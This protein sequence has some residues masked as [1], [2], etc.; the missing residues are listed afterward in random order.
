MNRI[1]GTI[2]NKAD[3]Y[4][5]YILWEERNLDFINNKSSVYAEVHI[6]CR[7]HSSYAS[8]LKQNLWING[9]HFE[10]VLSVSLSP[11]TDI[12][13][14]SGQVDN[15]YHEADG[16][17]SINISSNSILPSGNG[18]GPVGGSASEWVW[19]THFPRQANF[20]GY[21]INWTWIDSVDIAYSLDR[22]VQSLLVSINDGPWQG[23]DIISGNWNINAVGR[24]YNLSPNTYYR[25][26]LKATV[27]GLDT[28]SDYIYVTTRDIARI[29]NINDFEHGNNVDMEISNRGDLSNL[30]LTM[31]IN[32]IQI[33]NRNVVGGSNT[34]IFSDTELDNLYKRYGS[35]NNLIATFILIG[36]GYTDIK[37][38]NIT[39]KGNQKTIKVNV[40]NNYKRGKIFINVDG[41]WKKAV[42]WINNN[43]IWK[44]GI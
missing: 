34:I 42:I 1:N 11:G 33:L 36:E 27:N 29:I 40:N 41:I 13:V 20:T 35:N 22:Q 19:I 24:I 43:K 9:T 44:R 15:I 30:N 7:A 6:Y 31:N 16:S 25:F 3:S 14:V 4:E 12:I 2:E 23:M 39:L 8:N 18:W 38:C 17:K 5:Y 21:Y 32:G 10:N 28:I 26:R 37:T